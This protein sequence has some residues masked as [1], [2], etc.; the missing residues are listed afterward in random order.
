METF[1]RPPPNYELLLWQKLWQRKLTSYFTLRYRNL[2]LIRNE[3]VFAW[4]FI[5]SKSKTQK[6]MD[7]FWTRSVKSIEN[8]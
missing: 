1:W 5:D 6:M 4:E 7:T 8:N 3:L 2:N